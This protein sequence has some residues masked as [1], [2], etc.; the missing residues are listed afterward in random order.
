M[1]GTPQRCRSTFT[2]GS[3]GY[4]PNHFHLQTRKNCSCR[5]PFSTASLRK[6]CSLL[7]LV[8]RVGVALSSKQRRVRPDLPSAPVSFSVALYKVFVYDDDNFR[9]CTNAIRRCSQ[10]LHDFVIQNFWDCK[11]GVV[12]SP[13]FKRH[14]RRSRVR[15]ASTWCV[16]VC[17]SRDCR[18]AGVFTF[19]AGEWLLPVEPFTALV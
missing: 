11:C 9:W 10:I 1:A 6:V 16:C 13:Y 3:I 2:L 19:R 15:T 14:S 4:I 12:H 5:A 7:L 8:R 17:A 18:S